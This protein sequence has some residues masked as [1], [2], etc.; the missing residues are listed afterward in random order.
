MQ[1]WIDI[2]ILIILIDPKKS[3]TLFLKKKSFT[4][5]KKFKTLINILTNKNKL[6]EKQVHYQVHYSPAGPPPMIQIDTRVVML[7]VFYYFSFSFSF[8]MMCESK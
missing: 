7:E 5:V 8:K 6:I 2:S 3:F 4:F 1:K